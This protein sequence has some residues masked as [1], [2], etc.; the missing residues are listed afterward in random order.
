MCVGYIGGDTS[1]AHVIAAMRGCG[2]RSR[3]VTKYE[4]KL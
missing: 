4:G 1:A 3:P 2:F